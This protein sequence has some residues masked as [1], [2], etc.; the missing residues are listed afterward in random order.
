MFNKNFLLHLLYLKQIILLDH[1]PMFH[2]IIE[3][4]I[5][6]IDSLIYFIQN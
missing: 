4:F 3:L 5:I 1:H 6:V 2:L